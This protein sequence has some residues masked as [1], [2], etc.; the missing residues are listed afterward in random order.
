MINRL[1]SFL[2]IKMPERKKRSRRFF[3]FGFVN[4]GFVLFDFGLALPKGIIELKEASLWRVLQY[5]PAWVS[6]VGKR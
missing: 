1:S 6:F 3:V 5:I 4:F 2:S